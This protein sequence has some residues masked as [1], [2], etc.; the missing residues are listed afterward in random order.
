MVCGVAPEVFD[1][2]QAGQP[3]KSKAELEFNHLMTIIHQFGGGVG[4]VDVKGMIDG[5]KQW[6]AKAS[7]AG[8]DKAKQEAGRAGILGKK[9]KKYWTLGKSSRKHIQHLIEGSSYQITIGGD[10]KK[11]HRMA[12]YR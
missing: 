5:I 8:L 11:C 12:W 2:S 4:T 9:L 1:V 6:L 7:P 3:P 10:A